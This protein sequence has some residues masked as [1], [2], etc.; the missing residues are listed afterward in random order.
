MPPSACSKRPMRCLS[1]PVKAP[2]SW[3]KS[4]D[5]SRFSWS[6]AQLT[7]MKL[8]AVALR[9][10]VDGAG[11]ELLAGAGLAAHE[12]GGVAL[13]DLLHDAEHGRQRAARPDDVVELVDAALRVAQV[14]DLVLH[15]TELEGLLDLDLH[16]FD[17]ERL[18]DVVERAGLH[19]LDGGGDGAERGHQHDGA[20]RV[21][22]LGGLE[23]LD[24]GAAAHAEIAHDDVIG[25]L[26]Q[27]LDGRVAVRRF[28]D[29]VT[30]L[31]ERLRQ[32]AA[33][34]LVVVG[35]QNPSHSVGSSFLCAC[36]HP[37]RVRVRSL[38]VL[39]ARQRQRHPH[40][41]PF[42]RR[43]QIETPVVRVHDALHDRKPESGSLRLGGE[44]DVEDLLTHVR[45]NPRA[46][47]RDFHQDGV[48]SA[49][50]VLQ[51]GLARR[52]ASRGP[53][54]RGPRRR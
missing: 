53:R 47:V 27:L 24:A 26:M 34:R 15:A 32:R 13:G 43:L 52:H 28:V 36:A 48:A 21:Q 40:A 22:R 11:D 45:G 35:D 19:R 30:V 31:G 4:S 51:A 5:S 7:L 46:V 39:D 23:H 44:E 37:M 6:A 17:L 49:A 18:L 50:A 14:V 54:R 29:F 20:R 12:H 38:P 41:R 25:A 42:R 8:R 10:V 3:P 2:F 9:V 33:Q 1:A 16:L